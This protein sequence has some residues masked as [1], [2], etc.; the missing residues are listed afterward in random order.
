VNEPV[1]TLGEALVALVPPQGETL[2]SASAL[3][4]H[5]GGSELNV[6]V[7]LARLGCDAQWLGVLGEDPMGMRVCAVLKAE[8]VRSDGVRIVPG[9]RT[10]IYLRDVARGTGREVA[11]YRSGS[12]AQQMDAALWPDEPRAQWLHLS[13]ITAA[14]GPGPRELMTRALDWA[15]GESVPVSFDPNFRPALWSR[16]E[17]APWLREFSRRVDFCLLSDVDARVLVGAAEPATALP[18]LRELGVSAAV[19]KRAEAP[20]VAFDHRGRIETPVDVVAEPADTV[21]AGDGFDAGFIA[22]PGARAVIEE[23]I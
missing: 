14:L 19:L 4:L 6:A 9:G 20:V 1:I 18:R 13:G 21:G 16:H 10:A 2:A 11:Y 3:D 17:A 22:P 5:V 8:G 23:A 15:I 12:A 7:G